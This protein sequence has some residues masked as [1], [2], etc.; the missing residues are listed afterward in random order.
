MLV[1]NRGMCLFGLAIRY[2]LRTTSIVVPSEKFCERKYA[3]VFM[4]QQGRRTSRTSGKLLLG[5][6]K[7]AA[8]MHI[9]S[10][11]HPSH[12]QPTHAIYA[13]ICSCQV[14]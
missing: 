6:Q 8:V 3:L 14:K 5:S 1:N 11:I 2:A 4:I 12:S 9:H 13:T 10:E 7:D